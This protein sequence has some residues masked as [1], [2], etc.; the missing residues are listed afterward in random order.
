MISPYAP[1]IAEELW[2]LFGHEDS[3]VLQQF[4]KFNADFIG[5]SSFVYPVSF[6]GKRRFDME[7]PLDMSTADI[8]KAVKEAPETKK[9]VGELNIKKIIIVPKK[10]INVVVG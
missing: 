6:N 8:E 7:L 2:H 10:I 9:W 4:P 1:H 5:D 3:V